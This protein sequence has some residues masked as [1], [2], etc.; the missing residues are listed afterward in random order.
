MEK[1]S[2]RFSEKL[3]G[4]IFLLKMQPIRS[5]YFE[6]WSNLPNLKFVAIFVIKHLWVDVLRIIYKVFSEN[7]MLPIQ[8]LGYT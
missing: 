4:L 6:N 7:N 1:G 8:L 3:T 2:D 5:Y